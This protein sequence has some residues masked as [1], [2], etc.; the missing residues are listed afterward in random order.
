VKGFIEKNTWLGLEDFYDALSQ[1]L[2]AEYN[3]PPA[4]AKRRTRKSASNHGQTLPNASMM[5]QTTLP[6]KQTHKD[7]ILLAKQTSVRGLGQIENSAFGD[8]VGAVG[9][10]QEKLS[11]I[12]IF[13]LIT[14]ISFNVI[15]YYKL[16]K[17]EDYDSHE[18]LR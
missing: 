10:K 12:V 11:W 18:V 6:S 7:E 16:W 2:L 3:I 15:L 17:L 1:A 14:L 13:L 5:M 4:K 9:K 8:N